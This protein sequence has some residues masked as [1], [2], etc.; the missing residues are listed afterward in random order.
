VYGAF[1]ALLGPE[2][3]QQFYDLHDDEPGIDVLKEF[4]DGLEGW[5]GETSKPRVRCSPPARLHLRPISSVTTTWTSA[6]C[7][8]VGWISGEL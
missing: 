6:T 1:E 3:I 2:Q 7:G 5:A 8:P 4:F